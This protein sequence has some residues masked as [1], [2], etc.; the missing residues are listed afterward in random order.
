MYCILVECTYTLYIILYMYYYY[1]YIVV[2]YCIPFH[3]QLVI[4]IYIKLITMMLCTNPT[5]GVMEVNN[6]YTCTPSWMWKTPKLLQNPQHSGIQ[7][8][9]SS[10]N[11]NLTP[12]RCSKAVFNDDIY[13]ATEE[14]KSDLNFFETLHWLVNKNPAWWEMY[15]KRNGLLKSSLSSREEIFTTIYQVVP[16]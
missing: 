13:I 15:C 3:L 10:N 8:I 6:K 1:I 5:R 12:G 14:K 4:N 16:R 7:L 2:Y 11:K 9:H